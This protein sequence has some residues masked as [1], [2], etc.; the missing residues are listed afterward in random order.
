MVTPVVSTPQPAAP[1]STPA[2]GTAGSGNDYTAK[3]INPMYPITPQQFPEQAV[4]P[5]A[6]A[7][8]ARAAAPSAVPVVSF[9]EQ[10]AAVEMKVYGAKQANLTVLQ[11]LEKIEVDSTGQTRAGSIL[12]RINALKKSYGL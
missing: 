8:P 2:A 10:L 4:S 5:F 11:R 6:T 12:D 3:P 1:S 9:D 7:Q